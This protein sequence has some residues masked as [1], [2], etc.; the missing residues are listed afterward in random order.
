MAD[1]ASQT[2]AVHLR[3][4]SPCAC[5]HSHPHHQLVLSLDGS[6]EL[7]I[8]GQGGR[9]AALTGVLVPEGERHT[10]CSEGENRFLVIDVPRSL[11]EDLELGGWVDRWS[12]GRFFPVPRPARRLAG[13]LADGLL[14]ERL[15]PACL[16]AWAALL[17]RAAA[18]T[19]TLGKPEPVRRA[20]SFIGATA[21][22]SVGV[23]DVARAAGVSPGHLH[24]LFR[25]HVGTTP[26]ELLLATRLD[27]ARV[28]LAETSLPIAEVALCCGFAD[29]ATLTHA[30]QRVLGITPGRLRAGPAARR[31]Y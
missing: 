13:L 25:S 27:R 12:R 21:L 10:F 11:P 9:V 6:L 3:S 28:L 16:R 8:E 14:R 1:A 17:L 7:E 20:L 2:A 29:Q 23:L 18:A 4:Y 24:A 26:R 31:K 5:A 22:G 30:M 19:D 15:P